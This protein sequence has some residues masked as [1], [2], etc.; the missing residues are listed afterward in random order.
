MNKLSYQQQRSRLARKNWLSLALSLIFLASVGKLQAEAQA[1]NTPDFIIYADALASGWA[2]WSWDSTIKFDNITPVQSGADSIAVTF[3][4]GFAGFSVR[5]PDPISTAGYTGIA[6]WI[7]GGV[8][9]TQL[10][11]QTQPSD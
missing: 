1:A 7:Y 10:N 8:G 9:G 5:A 4:A 3:Q 6:F 2:N 11:L